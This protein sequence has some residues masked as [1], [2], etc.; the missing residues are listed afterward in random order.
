MDYIADIETNLNMGPAE[1]DSF[2]TRLFKSKDKYVR[3]GYLIGS[4][5]YA[6]VIKALTSSFKN[7]KKH[8]DKTGEEKQLLIDDMLQ[9][10]KKLENTQPSEERDNMIRVCENCIEVFED[11]IKCFKMEEMMSIPFDQDFLDWR[12]AYGLAQ[13]DRIKIQDKRI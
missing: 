13:K 1:V 9:L 7:I 6:V 3:E 8:F 2:G 11:D 10:L 12:Y 5:K 4:E